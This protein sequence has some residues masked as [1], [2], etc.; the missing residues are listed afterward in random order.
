MHRVAAADPAEADATQISAPARIGGGLTAAIVGFGAGQAV[1]GRWLET[2]WKYTL[3]ET[4]V[5]GLTI[6]SAYAFAPPPCTARECGGGPGAG[7]FVIV[8]GFV[9]LGVIRV[10]ETYDAASARGAHPVRSHAGVSALPYV[11]PSQRGDGAIA[12]AVFRL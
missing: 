9:A 4:A 6:G 7:T 1:Q 12:G 11:A 5:V 2:G 10:L 8:G 3:S